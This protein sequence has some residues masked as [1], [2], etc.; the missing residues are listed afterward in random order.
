M[1]K[2]PWITPAPVYRRSVYSFD[3]VQP[4]YL[5]DGVQQPQMALDAQWSADP[6]T[7]AT[8]VQ[9]PGPLPEWVGSSPDP[10]FKP[11]YFPIGTPIGTAD[12]PSWAA[13]DHNGTLWQVWQ[14][15]SGVSVAG[16]VDDPPGPPPLTGEAVDVEVEGDPVLLGAR[17][18]LLTTLFETAA[19][20]QDVTVRHLLF[21]PSWYEGSTVETLR[22]AGNIPPGFP[23]PGVEDL[24][25]RFDLNLSAG[26]VGDGETFGNEHFDIEFDVP[27]ADWDDND[28]LVIGGSIS[29]MEQG[30]DFLPDNNS[31]FM[32][33]LVQSLSGWWQPPRYRMV[34]P[35]RTPLRGRQR[36]SGST[37]SIPLRGPS[38]ATTPYGLRGRQESNR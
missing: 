29:A 25:S 24:P 8:I 18:R 28:L 33:G 38:R 13:F 10:W 7:M 31:L 16:L 37:G 12:A 9:S 4:P 6:A 35:S 21:P 22:W 17:V 32:S 20:T 15:F 3:G 23:S 27:L 34:Y 36:T 11:S 14:S 1:K 30:S 19:F 2:G 5:P 26:Y